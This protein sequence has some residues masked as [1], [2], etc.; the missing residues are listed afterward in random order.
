[1]FQAYQVGRPLL[2]RCGRST[3]TAFGIKQNSWIPRANCAA[4]MRKMSH[5]WTTETI[6]SSFLDGVRY[7]GIF[8]QAER[9]CTYGCREDLTR[10]R[11]RDGWAMHQRG[12]FPVSSVRSAEQG[13]ISSAR[14]WS[15]CAFCGICVCY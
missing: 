1:M 9:E 13:I 15:Q 11:P 14:G 2:Q 4:A 12:G 8:I 3:S 6:S 5:L 7:P 10:A